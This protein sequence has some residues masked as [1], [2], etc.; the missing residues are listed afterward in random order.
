M[1]QPKSPSPRDVKSMS[2]SSADVSFEEDKASGDGETAVNNGDKE[3]DEPSNAL[4]AVDDARS[5]L[6]KLNLND[7][8]NAFRDH[9]LQTANDAE[10]GEE[11]QTA[12]TPTSSNVRKKEQQRE[13]LNP[14]E[15]GDVLDPILSQFSNEPSSI[16]S[17][18]DSSNSSI[19][20][21]GNNRMQESSRTHA[22]NNTEGGRDAKKRPVEA[23]ET[24]TTPTE[25][26]TKRARVSLS[27]SKQL[28]LTNWFVKK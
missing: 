25:S 3:T 6:E 24:T 23:D 12:V 17:F 21:E 28:T 4:D 26:R 19:S 8:C 16:E 9:V 13:R 22:Q 2:M 15:G 1:E 20:T 27:N 14:E 18:S 5:P 11:Y 7:R 10:S